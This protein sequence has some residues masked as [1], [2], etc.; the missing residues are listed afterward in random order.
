MDFMDF[1]QT[2][3][4]ASTAAAAAAL[5]V[6]RSRWRST[7]MTLPAAAPPTGSTSFVVRA[8][9][10][11]DIAKVHA[12]IMALAT[13]EE[14]AHRVE[15]TPE[16][17]LRDFDRFRIV[18]AEDPEG[19]LLGFA[20]FSLGYSTWVGPTVAMDDLFVLEAHRGRGVGSALLRKSAEE[21]RRRG[22]Q[23]MEWLSFRW[24]VDA[25]DFYR[26]KL[27]AKVQDAL[28]YWRLSADGMQAM[29]CRPES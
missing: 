20:F 4:L 19:V 6:F 3:A 12:L 1:S 8:A 29:L 15:T 5:V 26:E 13:F 9:E 24:N 7:S 18:V 14:S 17:L 25:N 11:A 27:G 2:L 22:A 21:G 23:R 16:T 10:R 28:F